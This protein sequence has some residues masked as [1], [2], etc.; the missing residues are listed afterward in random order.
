MDS[1]RSG[2]RRAARR[3]AL[4]AVLAVIGVLALAGCTLG[5]SQ[6]PPLATSASAGAAGATTPPSSVI[7]PGGPGR[8]VDPIEWSACRDLDPVDPATGARYRVD[9]GEVVAPGAA[10]DPF[11]GRVIGVSR[12]R[13]PG[14]ADDAPNLVVLAGEPG[15]RGRADVVR[16]AADLSADV[17]DRFAIVTV[18]L[19]G[20][21][22]MGL[23]CLAPSDAR[24]LT[25]LGA[26]PTI[27]NAADALAGLSRSLVIACGDMEGA[28]LTSINST[29]AADDLDSVRAALGEQTINLLGQGFGAT[30]AAVYA[31]RY[32]GRV[33]RLVLDGP[34]DPLQDPVSHAAAVARAQ[35]AALEA[36]A[37][38]C[39]SF[40][41][42]CP[43]GADPATAVSDL[44]GGLDEASSPGPGLPTG[45][46]VL[47]LLL[48]ELG[49][50]TG[51][52]ELAGTLA[53]AVQGDTGQ[54]EA[55]IAANL[56]LAAPVRW[57]AASI[58]YRC[59]D[60]ALRMSPQQM[61]QAV[62]EIRADAPLFGPFAMGLIGIC[63][64]WPAPDA[65]LGAVTAAG[66]PPF[67]VLGSVGDPVAPYPAVQSLVG[68]MGSARLLSWQS[69]RHGAY[70]ASP[71]VTHA[72]DD[73]LA[74]GALPLVGTL[75]PP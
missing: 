7:G 68:Q 36:F 43:L 60:T 11:G 18:D 4:P 57:I 64:S 17:R 27:P 19:G 50:P 40:A 12:A 66:T 65:A 54:L 70:P 39:Q 5:P 52:P 63:A 51:W 58:V 75:C 8:Q 33:E 34:A 72:V 9:C 69:S 23:D 15:Q 61:E 29:T 16:A 37:T 56:G 26:D 71:C 6:R 2:P 21:G 28:G 44:V 53:A 31:H 13:A 32:P 3:R 1:T 20:T 62:S 46:T 48:L 47:L 41:G 42:G 73:Y 10:G 30:L 67:L 35:T 45:G 25:S 24:T 55:R 14:V 74:G 38:A 49:D 59:N 22:P